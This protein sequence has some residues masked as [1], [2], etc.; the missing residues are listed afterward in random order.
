MVCPPAIELLT[1]IKDILKRTFDASSMS[2]RGNNNGWNTLNVGK[3]W[4]YN[5]TGTFAGTTTTFV[6]DFPK[7]VQLNRVVQLFNDATAK[8]YD[9][10]IYSQGGSTLYASLDTKT[11]DT[12]TQIVDLT[13][14]KIGAL[15]RISIV[16]ASYTAGKTFEIDIQVD[17]L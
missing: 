12:S 11:G 13:D 15:G 2:I 7:A 16:Y 10:R 8:N 14:Y 3:S 5:R 1:E 17:E 4:V 9:V 6:I